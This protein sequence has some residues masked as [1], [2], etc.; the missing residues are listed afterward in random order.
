MRC[1]KEDATVQ[2]APRKA[3]LLF[4][5][6]VFTGV[7]ALLLL[8]LLEG[9]ASIL[10]VL[11][12]PPKA[13]L[14]QERTHTE[15]DPD[16][17]WINL[18]QLH[19]ENM[20]GPGTSFT[21]NAQRFRSSRDFAAEIPAGK[22]R[23]ICSGDSFTLGY[24]VDDDETWCHRLEAID[25][26]LETVNMGQNGYGID[27]AYLWYERDGRRLA[28]DVHVLAFIDADLGRMASNTFAGY[29][30]P[31]VRIENGSVLVPNT[32]VP[33]ASYRMPALTRWLPLLGQTRIA[34]LVNS[35]K[36]PVAPSD[37]DQRL[38]SPQLVDLAVALFEDLD[39][40]HGSSGVRFVVVRLPSFEDYRRE[41]LEPRKSLS[42]KMA[43]AGIEYLDLGEQANLL[44]PS[45]YSSLFLEE[46]RD[47][48]RHPSPRGHEFIAG[49]I[50]SRFVQDLPS[51][52]SE[53]SR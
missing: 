25:A 31:S 21:T 36:P 20:Y 18:P 17:G 16:L 35:F 30:K 47:P 15:Y 29:G 12:Q 43:E 37:R 22:H 33:R 11:H 42:R 41:D 40:A 4:R 44:E 48:Y 34:Q 49:L 32:P 26:T 7:L 46:S 28:H 6:L 5:A 10:F 19:V 27:Q 2:S 45:E 51:P 50:H 14:V 1:A 8:L 53:K 38:T 24:G 3:A 52:A 23:V 39:R 9:M 13:A